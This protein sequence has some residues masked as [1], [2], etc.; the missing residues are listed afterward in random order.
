MMARK[1]Q[2]QE[3]HYNDC[4]SDTAGIDHD[5]NSALLLTSPDV[6]DWAEACFGKYAEDECSSESSSLIASC[7]HLHEP[8]EMRAMLSAIILNLPTFTVAIL[9]ITRISVGTQQPSLFP[10]MGFKLGLPRHLRGKL[11]SWK[12]LAAKAASRGSQSASAS[13]Q[14][15]I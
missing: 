11:I 5:A 14:D 10:G 4:G 2:T 15:Q 3:E 13:P 1:P 6:D 8:E 9:T 12:Y 7:Q